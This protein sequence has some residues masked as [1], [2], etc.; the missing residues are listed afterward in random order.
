MANTP[1]LGKMSVA[2]LR[3]MA[4]ALEVQ[5][6]EKLKK[7]EII[8][9]IEKIAKQSESNSSNAEV[10]TAVSEESSAKRKRVPV[11]NELISTEP[12]VE[13]TEAKVEGQDTT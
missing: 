7:P 11:K 6:A 13:I 10:N 8:A 5:G 4:T 2:E 1:D 12:V 3:T 9:A